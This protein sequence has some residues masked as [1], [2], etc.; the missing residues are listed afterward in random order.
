[1]GELAGVLMVAVPVAHIQAVA[2]RQALSM[3]SGITV[4]FLLTALVIY[5]L[6]NRLVLEPVGLLTRRVEALSRGEGLDEPLPE[7]PKD[8]VGRL[9]RAVELLR[10]SL[11]LLSE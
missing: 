6:L 2:T 3:A 7:L 4:L 11:K 5:G 10:R 1:V 9:A 8:E